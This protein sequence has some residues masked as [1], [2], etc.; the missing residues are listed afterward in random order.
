MAARC[1]ETVG[2]ERHSTGG[3]VGQKGTGIVRWGLFTLNLERLNL[4]GTN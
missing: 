3:T 4:E 1:D 2:T